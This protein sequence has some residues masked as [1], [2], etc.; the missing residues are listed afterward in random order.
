MQRQGAE[1]LLA[2]DGGALELLRQEL[3][4]LTALELPSYQIRYASSNMI[5]NIAPQFPKI[6]RA[7]SL[8]NQ[9]VK[10]MVEDFDIHGIL[11]DNR[12]GCHHPAVPGVFLTHQ[13]FIKTPFPLMDALV[14]WGNFHFIK[15]FSK[16]WVPDVQGVPNLSGEL[17]HRKR[18]GLPNVRYIG[19]LSRMKKM[20]AEKKYDAIAVLSGP[21]P[22][23]S[24]FEKEIIEQAGRLPYRFLIVQGKP[25][26]Q[27]HF[28]H[29]KNVEIVSNL[30]TEALN[31]AILSSGLFI[32]RSGYSTIMDLA[33]LEKPALLVPT[34]GQTEQEYLAKKFYEEKKCLW[35]RQGQLD[36]KKAFDEVGNCRMTGQDYFD[37]TLLAA[38]V[39][40]FL[41]G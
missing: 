2:S 24:F 35:Q 37:E 8:E 26:K 12:F 41:A 14:E 10:K 34:P 32:G 25:E 15:K 29:Q 27:A 3:P 7:V 36:L 18:K 11:S 9:A 4:G 16:C 6:M 20:E 22:Q 33:K 31:E 40:K 28:F 38:A 13:L 30:A 19:A 39:S 5:L 23:R 21:E 17:S 1:I